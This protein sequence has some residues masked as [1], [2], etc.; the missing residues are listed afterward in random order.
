MGT[1]EACM[2]WDRGSLAGIK[3]KLNQVLKVFIRSNATGQTNR[4]QCT[5]QKDGSA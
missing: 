3:Y 4:F 2:Q 5:R 1:T